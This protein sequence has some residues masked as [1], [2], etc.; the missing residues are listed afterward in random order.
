MV[1]DKKELEAKAVIAIETVNLLLERLGYSEIAVELFASIFMD[2]NTANLI[3]FNEFLKISK[4]SRENLP[5]HINS[6]HE[7]VRKLIKHRLDNNV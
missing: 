3:G 5:L 2:L 4:M 6:D 1:N 7:I